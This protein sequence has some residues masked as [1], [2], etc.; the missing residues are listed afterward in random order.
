M[1]TLGLQIPE[2][3]ITVYPSNAIYLNSFSTIATSLSHSMVEYVVSITK[4]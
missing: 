3:I 1:S 4:R 2:I